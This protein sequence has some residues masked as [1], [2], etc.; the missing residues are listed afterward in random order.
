MPPLARQESQDASVSSATEAPGIEV[1]MSDEFVAKVRMFEAA[2][3]GHWAFVSAYLAR[4]QGW[5]NEENPLGSASGFKLVHQAAF[6]GASLPTLIRLHAAGANFGAKTSDQDGC[7]TPAQIAEGKGKTRCAA[8]ITSILNGEYDAD[9]VPTHYSC[10]ITSD[11]M[12]DPVRIASGSIFERSAIQ[13][14][15]AQRN[16]DPLTNTP[17]PNTELTP[18]PELQAEIRSFLEANPHLSSDA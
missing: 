13:S 16:T 14:W 5:V 8:H 15:L 1:D 2:F 4:E 3:M 18:L 10:A 11:I 9:G 12:T 7:R 6:Y 17:L